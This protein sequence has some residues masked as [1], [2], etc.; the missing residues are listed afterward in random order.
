M[1]IRQTYITAW[2]I[3]LLAVALLTA[4]C[5]EEPSQAR[6]R[7]VLEGQIESERTANVLLTWSVVPEDEGEILDKVIKWGKVTI[8]DG[9]SEEILAA[10]PIRDWYPPYRY[11]TLAMRGEPGKTYTVTASYRG[12]KASASVRMPEPTPIS[13]V[14]VTSIEGVD[15]LRSVVLRFVSPSDCPA[16][17]YLSLRSLNG[18]RQ[19]LPCYLGTV[20]VAIPG[21]E[22]SI[23]VFNPKT[24]DQRHYTSNLKVGESYEISLNRVSEE[25]YRF[26]QAFNEA[27]AFGHNPFLSSSFNLTGNISGGLGVWSAQGTSRYVL[28]L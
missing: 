13:G 8:S 12:Q 20:S 27:V 23:G 2:Y 3:L 1:T 5:S 25:V 28:S 14:E 24:I 19:T 15:S 18:R 26:R 9:D 16:Y 21:Q 10:G 7:L 6:P 22:V 4:S 11:Y 17:Y